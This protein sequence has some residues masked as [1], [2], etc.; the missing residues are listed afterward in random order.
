MIH[1]VSTVFE[2]ENLNLNFEQMSVKIGHEVL[3]K[4]K[5]SQILKN[6]TTRKQGKAV[7]VGKLGRIVTVYIANLAK[8]MYPSVCD[9]ES[10]SWFLR[11]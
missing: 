11:H 6:F 3:I 7:S 10:Q 8:Y 2:L 1:S 4:R 5:V 9:G